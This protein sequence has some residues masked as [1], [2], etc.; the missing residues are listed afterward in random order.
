[1]TSRLL[2]DLSVQHEIE[3]TYSLERWKLVEM[4]TFVL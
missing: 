3:A 2:H 4:T 1:M